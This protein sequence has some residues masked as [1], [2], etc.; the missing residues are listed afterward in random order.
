MDTFNI[1]ALPER[2]ER[3]LQ[4]AEA[5]KSD[6]D[7]EVIHD[8][9]IASRTVLAL[10]P[11]LR[12]TSATR[13]WRKPVKRW[14]KA[15]NHLRDLQVMQEHFGQHGTL[16]NKLS[17]SIRAEL[18]TWEN[19][20]PDIAGKSF[21]RRLQRSLERFIR[22]C[23]TYPG[24]F[25]VTTLSL[26]WQTL[27]EVQTRFAAIR[28]DDPATLHRL[29]IAFKSLRYLTNTLRNLNAIPEDANTGLKYWH[30]LLG[31]I[32]DRQV[33]QHWLDQADADPALTG[34]QR[35]EAASLQE[36]FLHERLKF[37]QMLLQLDETVTSS[38]R[39]MLRTNTGLA[40]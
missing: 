40:A 2:I 29:R 13:K 17:S 31:D 26:W 32:Q 5:V 4:L 28:P 20:R 23:E 9:R 10:E 33:A 35:E 16:D 8:F 25:A 12:T 38:L 24:Y 3:Y 7:P 14:L 15:L 11:L 36:T 1:N 19:I 30:D 18:N 34:Q 22:C 21:Q 6:N 27:G 39:H 37:Q